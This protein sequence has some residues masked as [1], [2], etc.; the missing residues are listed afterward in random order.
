[1]RPAHTI[2]TVVTPAVLAAGAPT[3]ATAYDLCLLSSFKTTWEVTVTTDDAFLTL[4]ITGCSQAAAKYCQRVSPRGFAFETVQDQILMQRDGWPR[5]VRPET[6]AFQLSRWPV[7]AI[8]SVTVDGNALIAGT[9]FLVD[10]ES[11]QLV[12][13]DINGKAIDWHGL[14]TIAIYQAGYVLPSQDPTSLPTGA[15]TLP[16]DVQDAVSRMAY[17]RYS[18]RQRDPLVKSKYVEGVYRVEYL[19]PAADGNLDPGVKEILDAYRVPTVG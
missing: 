8:E 1:M 13:L 10:N 4:A 2:V 16:L 9:D 12:R 19:V 18:E 7:F 3:G 17:T 15:P 6:D 11:G 14:Q 5:A